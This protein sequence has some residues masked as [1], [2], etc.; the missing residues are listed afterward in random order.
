[1]TCW[2]ASALPSILVK[3]VVYFSIWALY[4]M[5]EEMNPSAALSAAEP[6]FEKTFAMTVPCV[7]ALARDLPDAL[8]VELAKPSMPLFAAFSAVVVALS[9]VSACANMVLRF[10][11]SED[12]L[13]VLPTDSL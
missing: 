8:S 6:S 5:P 4:S 3:P 13:P 7:M 9:C 11:V 1:M 12:A 10:L 2:A